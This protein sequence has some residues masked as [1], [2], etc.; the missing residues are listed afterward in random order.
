L[1]I[2]VNGESRSI[3]TGT[4][5]QF[6]ESLTIDPARVAV[7]LNQEILPKG[8]YVSTLLQEGDRIEIVHF[9]GGG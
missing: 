1:Q 7:E 2:V 8:E 3:S 6:L 9:V 5:R 4:V